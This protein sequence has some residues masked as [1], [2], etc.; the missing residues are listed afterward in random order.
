MPS[1]FPGMDPWLEAPGL[2][3][4]F[5]NRY[6]A[7]LSA[8]MNAVLPPPY[9][10]AIGTRVV[11]HGDAERFIEPDLDILYP[12]DTHAVTATAVA[13]VRPIIV[14]VPRDESTEWFVEVR[15]GDGENELV[16]AVEVL[17][18]S[19]KQ[20][21]GGRRDYL[22][23]QRELIE[24]GVNLLELD[25]LR[26]GLHTTA[27]PIAAVRANVGRFDYH[28]CGRRTERP[29]DYEIYPILLGEPLPAV[30]LPLRDGQTVRIEL[31]APF[32]RAYD[33]AAFAR[34]VNYARPPA[35]PL[36]PEQAAAVHP[37]L[38]AR[39]P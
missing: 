27:V 14:H 23:K 35:P 11:V 34:R 24:R 31:Q 26:G 38:G 3:P 5:H 16:T 21:G 20:P 25:F 7:V 19:N 10:A 2:F 22:R 33:E 1:P 30:G 29:E 6:I 15:T 4:D 18:A 39:A 13:D 36:T 37:F 17:S 12:P 32:A 28:A 8:A 9:F